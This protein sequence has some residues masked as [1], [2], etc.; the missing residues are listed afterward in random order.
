MWLGVSI[1][2]NWI[3]PA[4]PSSPERTT[5]HFFHM[6]ILDHIKHNWEQTEAIIRRNHTVAQIMAVHC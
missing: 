4:K 6:P 2:T 1:A 5:D 3:L